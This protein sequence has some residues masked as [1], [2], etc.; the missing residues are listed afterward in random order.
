[1]RE[2]HSAQVWAWWKPQQTRFA[3]AKYPVDSVLD[4]QSWSTRVS[5]PYWSHWSDVQC[6]T[7]LT[8]LVFNQWPVLLDWSSPWDLVT[9]LSLAETFYNEV[10]SDS[11]VRIMVSTLPP[12]CPTSTLVWVQPFKVVNSIRSEPVGTA[13]STA[14]MLVRVWLRWLENLGNGTGN[15]FNQM[16]FDRESHRNNEPR[17]WV[18]TGTNK[19]S[20]HPRSERWRTGNILQPKFWLRSTV[21]SSEPSTRSTTEVS[22]HRIAG[23]FDLDIDA[24]GRWS[25]EKFKGLL[26]QIER[27]LRDPQRTRRGKATPSCVHW[28]S[29]GS[30]HGWY[31]GLHPALNTT[32]TLT[33]PQHLVQSTVSSVS[34]STHIQPTVDAPTPTLVTSITLSVIRVHLM[35]LVC[36]TVLMFLSKWLERWWEHLPA[37]I[38]LKTRYGIV[39]PFM[40]EQPRVLVDSG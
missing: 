1:M 15:Q 28:R 8:W 16:V 12:V 21:K 39:N 23:V 13:S 35:T 26:F 36:S 24:N 19:T 22:Q 17:G 27:D 5:T 29:S 4:H 40:K 33:T 11:L 10:D 18:L 14:I 25:V 37:K 38:E 31:P 30:D 2:Q 6:L 9:S 32:W 7:H 34:T 3:A 20:R